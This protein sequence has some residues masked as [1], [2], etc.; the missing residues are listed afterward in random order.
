MLLLPR[1]LLEKLEFDK[2]S[3]ITSSYCYGELGKERI[4]RLNSIRKK[5]SI[6][7]YYMF[8]TLNHYLFE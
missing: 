5:E 8:I 2:L 3:E 4:K 7:L 1:D 6:N